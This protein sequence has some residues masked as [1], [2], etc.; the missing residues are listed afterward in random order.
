[1]IV[2]LS[3]V[4]TARQL[5]LVL[6]RAFGFPPMY[7]MNWDAYWDAITGLVELPDEITFTGWARLAEKLPRDAEILRELMDDYLAEPYA[8]FHAHKRITFE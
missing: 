3:E 7:G 5:H 1:M 4:E 8:A 6:K 2:D